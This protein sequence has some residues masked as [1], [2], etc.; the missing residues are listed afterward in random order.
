VSR[1]SDPAYRLRE[2]K[3]NEWLRKAVSDLPILE[4]R[5]KDIDR[6][7]DAIAQAAAVGD[8]F[9]IVPRFRSSGSETARKSLDKVA[10]LSA[11]LAQCID[12]MPKE[13]HEGI[14]AVRAKQKLYMPLVDA[15]RRVTPSPPVSPTSQLLFEAMCKMPPAVSPPSPEDALRSDLMAFSRAAEWARDQLAQRPTHRKRQLAHQVTKMAGLVYE[16]LTG[17]QVTRSG[18]TTTGEGS[19]F[20][21]FLDDVFAALEIPANT[22][23]MTRDYISDKSQQK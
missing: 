18:N 21:N 16:A 1:T 23:R 14:A 22:D 11:R 9:D 3:A 12:E 15:M 7:A 20:Q 5:S 8:A 19:P 10:S 2:C 13:A 17:L 6:F 4:G